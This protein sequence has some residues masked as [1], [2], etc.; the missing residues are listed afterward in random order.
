MKLILIALVAL[1]AG[2][3]PV[4][5]SEDFINAIAY[6]KGGA[7]IVSGGSRLDSSNRR[8]GVIA[9]SDAATGRPVRQFVNPTDEVLAIATTPDGALLATCDG[10]RFVKLWNLQG[11]RPPRTIQGHEERV[12]SL[13]FSP[14]GQTLATCGAGIVRLRDV[15]TGVLIG[16]MRA[17]EEEC[18]NVVV[19]SRDGARL[20]AVGNSGVL[21]VWDVASGRLLLNV[22]AGQGSINSLALSPDGRIIATAG[23]DGTVRFWNAV[24]G[25]SI[26]VF[27]PP[28]L[29][30]DRLDPEALWGPIAFSPDGSVL[31]AVLFG[32][33]VRLWDTQTCRVMRNIGADDL[34]LLT[35]AFSPD[36][37]RLATGTDQGGRLRFW[38]W[39]TGQLLDKDS[40]KSPKP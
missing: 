36:G 32:G 31:A 6:L 21:R 22:R 33:E 34:H 20:A 27:R 4:D 26:K 40:P 2:K 35:A 25:I 24:T 39:T 12:E 17:D 14:D 11:D 3:G 15:A 5:D 9:L 13:A 23:E 10:Q 7:T 16:S 30:R 19:F 37:R 28:H 1:A 18:L 29:L 8:I 38:D